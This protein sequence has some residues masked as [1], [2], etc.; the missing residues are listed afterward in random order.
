MSRAVIAVLIVVTLALPA[1]SRAG[2]A[3]PPNEWPTT[4]PEQQ[5]FDSAKL[6]EALHILQRDVPGLHSLVVIGDGKLMVDATFYPYDGTSP[7]DLG[8]VTKSVLTTL[9]GIAIDQGTLHLDDPVLS[10]FPDRTIANRDE[11]KERLT[12]AHLASNAS[13]LA[14]LREPAE[15]TQA[16]MAASDDWVQF[17]LDLPMAAEPGSTWEY[18]S[19]GFHLLS[20]ANGPILPEQI[21]YLSIAIIQSQIY[22][23]F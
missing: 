4:T 8:S 19:P 17:V 14:C 7:H 16:A 3:A 23:P 22:H 18:C 13:G 5:G 9:I 10:F 20:P 2:G 21:T 6:A 12:I 11:R 1:G 15:P